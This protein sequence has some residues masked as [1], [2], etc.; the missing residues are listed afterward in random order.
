MKNLRVQ[1]KQVLGGVLLEIRSK[2]FYYL[3]QLTSEERVEKTRLDSMVRFLHE[4]LGIAIP[5]QLESWDVSRL[6]HG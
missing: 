5:D 3:Q 6:K 2:V 4:R 1:Y